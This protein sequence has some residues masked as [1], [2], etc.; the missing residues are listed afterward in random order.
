M[1]ASRDTEDAEQMA[2]ILQIANAS[3]VISDAAREIVNVVH[4]KTTPDDLVI[5]AL[6]TSDEQ[7]ISTVVDK[8]SDIVGK[9]FKEI[10]L[11]IKT[12]MYILVVR[13]D[14]QWFYKPRKSFMFQKGDVI[15]ARG[16]DDGVN[17]LKKITKGETRL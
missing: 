10:K 13:R 11:A 6:R 3:E 16:L 8:N 1:L 2:A 12:G 7:I 5:E 9:T 4:Q 14:D 17:L 15:I